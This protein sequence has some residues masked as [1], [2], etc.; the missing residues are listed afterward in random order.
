MPGEHQ[1]ARHAADGIL[2]TLMDYALSLV[3]V[4]LISPLLILLALIVKLDSPGPVI[5]RRRV[6]GRGGTQFDAWKFRTMVVNGDEILAAHP[7]LKARWERDQK[8]EDDPRVTRS[9]NWMRKLSLDE[10]PQLFNVL[11]GQMSLVGPRMFA[12]VELVRYGDAVD[13]ILSVKPGITGL[14]QVSGRSNLSYADRAR[15]DLEYTRTCSVW[16]DLKLL[17]LT[18]PAVLQK[19]GAF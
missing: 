7:D 8:L 19:R 5:Y 14:W 18:V 1:A 10:L 13:E 16:M 9:G 6:M 15:L 11:C 12:P 17:V 4:V 3:V 2:K